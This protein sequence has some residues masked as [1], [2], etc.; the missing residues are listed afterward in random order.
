MRYQCLHNGIDNTAHVAGVEG[1][2]LKQRWRRYGW[3]LVVWQGMEGTM[4][5]GLGISCM[6]RCPVYLGSTAVMVTAVLASSSLGAYLFVEIWQGVV[7]AVVEEPRGRWARVLW[8]DCSNGCCRLFHGHAAPTNC[9]VV[10]Q[11]TTALT[12]TIK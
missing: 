4:L 11:A 10:L 8:G 1:C 3:L 12:D 2:M 7:D 5:S 6:R 9:C